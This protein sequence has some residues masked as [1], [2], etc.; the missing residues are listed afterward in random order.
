VRRA[1]AVWY[2]LPGNHEDEDVVE[3]SRLP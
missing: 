1:K 3:A 2:T